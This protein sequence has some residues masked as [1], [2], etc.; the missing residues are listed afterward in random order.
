MLM[1]TVF[2]RIIHQFVIQHEYRILHISET[3]K[4]VWLESLRNKDAPI[5]R[6]LRYD[7]DWAMW[8]KRDIEKTTFQVEQFR[9]QLFKRDL[10]AV[11]IYVSTYPPVDD[12]EPLMEREGNKEK[13]DVAPIIL[14][15][16]NIQEATKKVSDVTK[17]PIMIQEDMVLDDL[18]LEHLKQSV[19]S[20]ANNRIKRER[21][22]F[23][24]GKPF[25]TYIFIAVQVIFFLLLEMNGGSQN[26][27][28]LIDYGAK[29]NPLIIDGEWWRFF[30][31]IVLHIGL[32][33]LVMN[34]LALYYIGSAVERIYG[35]ARF[36]F[37]YLFAGFTGSVA[38]FIFTP[39]V[40]AGASGAIFGC[41]GALLFVGIVMPKLFLRTMGMNILVIVGI[42]LSLGFIIPGIDN[43]GHI[44]GL[45]GGFLAAS[46]VSLPRQKKSVRQLLTVL[47]TAAIVFYGLQIGYTNNAEDPLVVATQVQQLIENEQLEEA[48]EKL[49]LLEGQENLPA[50]IYFYFSYIEIKQGE[51]QLARENLEKAI[52]IQPRFHE[53]HYNLSLVYIE[54]DE[55]ELALASVENAIEI[56][57]VESYTRVREE[58]IRMLG[59]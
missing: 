23:Q 53:A 3:Q 30:T 51:L 24:Y 36:L 35:S 2:W 13:V 38:S 19:V 50:E 40:S 22:V 37:M 56:E 16:Q 15:N 43:A 41:F 32:L 21:D 12:W 6:L 58:L 31:P 25:F 20:V 17:K 29:Y 55:L 5:I 14:H 34:T 8:L 59:E 47:V 45:V 9:K 27:Q 39:S 1:D 49:A 7:L 26:I 57:N 46:I 48:Y 28:T 4:E 11:S 44:G 42:N 52:A 54:L 18:A 10:Q 33:H